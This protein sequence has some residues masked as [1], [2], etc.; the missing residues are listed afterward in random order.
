M[1]LVF[2]GKVL[3]YSTSCQVCT[4]CDAIT[5]NVEKQVICIK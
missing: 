1:K 2:R 3:W 4:D 5:A